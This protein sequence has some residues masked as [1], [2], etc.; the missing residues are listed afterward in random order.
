MIIWIMNTNSI[1]KIYLI[2][3]K[4]GQNE[5]SQKNN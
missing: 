3:L 4:G 2:K 5:T 1:S